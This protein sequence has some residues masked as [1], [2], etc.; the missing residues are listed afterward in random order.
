[1]SKDKLTGPISRPDEQAAA[2]T[3]LA[4]DDAFQIEENGAQTLLVLANDRGTSNPNVRRVHA[5][6]AAGAP[7]IVSIAPDGQ[8]LRYDPGAAFDHL[9]AGE[10][11]TVEFGYT[12]R[13]GKGAYDDALVRLTVTG[14][15]DAPVANDADLATD[16]D[17]RLES[18]LDASDVEGDALAFALI[19]GPAHGELVLAPDGAFTYAPDA[20]YNGA[21]GFTYTVDDGNGGA[22][23]GTVRLTVNPVND[24]A[25]IGG[26]TTGTVTED[27]HVDSGLLKTG[28]T[29]TVSDVDGADEEAFQPTD[30]IAGAYGTFTLA[31]N[32]E[33]TYSAGNDQEAIQSLDEGQTHTDSFTVLSKD[34]TSQR[35][36]V[37]ING[38]DEAPTEPT[39]A[40][41]GY[42]DMYAGAGV[43]SQRPAILAAGH[44][45][46]KI[47][48]WS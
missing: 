27:T 15:N 33:W 42:Y 31:A 43:P 11:A 25:V 8:S 38:A 17:T 29:L 26:A 21:D 12:L 23:T 41:V 36:T 3:G 6:D 20:N 18:R 5:V 35:L 24:K 16:E 1:M 13:Q 44:E 7:G 10:T 14:V 22:D 32:G 48:T 37:T 28:G 4:I 2:Q 47:S 34:G 39:I 45:P 30:N 19:D 40:Q 46:V 9:G